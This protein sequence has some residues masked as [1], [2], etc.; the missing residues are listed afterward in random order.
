MSFVDNKYEFQM[1]KNKTVVFGEH[2]VHANDH[3]VSPTKQ[4]ILNII[5]SF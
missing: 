5:I 3:V 1:V 4:K 2:L